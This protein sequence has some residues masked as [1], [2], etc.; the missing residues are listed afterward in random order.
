MKQ[1]FGTQLEVLERDI[2][3]LYGFWDMEFTFYDDS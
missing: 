2:E 1:E 3:W